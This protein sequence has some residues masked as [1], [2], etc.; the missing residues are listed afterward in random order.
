MKTIKYFLAAIAFLA[1]VF[2]Y[3]NRDFFA[4]DACLD[5]GGAWDETVR[6]CRKNQLQP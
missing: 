2:V 1:A 5:S 4:I 3:S 6:A